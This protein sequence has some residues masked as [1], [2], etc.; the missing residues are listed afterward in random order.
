MLAETWQTEPSKHSLP[1]QGFESQAVGTLTTAIG[2][3][4][5]A[6]PS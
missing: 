4:S 6:C 2:N 3:L 1:E 5:A